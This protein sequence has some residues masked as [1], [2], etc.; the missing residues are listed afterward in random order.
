MSGKRRL[1]GA[2]FN[3]KLE[4]RTNRG[5][6]WGLDAEPPRRDTTDRGRGGRGRGGRGNS[7]TPKPS[8][9][10]RYRSLPTGSHASLGSRSLAA[11]ALIPQRD[12]V[13]ESIVRRNAMTLRNAPPLSDNDVAKW[14]TSLEISRGLASY[15][16]TV[17]RTAAPPWTHATKCV[18]PLVEVVKAASREP[19]DGDDTDDHEL[20]AFP[21]LDD[22]PLETPSG[23]SS[24]VS[25]SD[26]ARGMM[27]KD[28]GGVRPARGVSGC[29]ENSDISG[30]FGRHFLA[31]RWALG[32]CAV[33]ARGRPRRRAAG[34]Q[35]LRRLRPGPPRS[36]LHRVRQGQPRSFPRG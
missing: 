33:H 7:T 31:G 18:S 9:P 12:H 22:M 32:G 23:M 8:R 24:A 27:W 16:T 4:I 29:L 28:P 11:T 21:H 3:N 6:D 25:S 2:Y 10:T 30:S 34:R 19:D 15:I 35:L 26:H 1:R 14:L 5:E 20:L 13:E 17:N 36:L